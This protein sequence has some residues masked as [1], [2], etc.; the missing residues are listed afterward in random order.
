MPYYAE[1]M[2]GFEYSAATLMIFHGMVAE[3]IE[4]IQ[5]TR[6]RY[7][8]EKA[9]PYDETEYGR[10]YARAMASWAAIPALSGFRY[11]APAARIELAPRLS[12]TNFQ[13]FW[14]TPAAWGSFALTPTAV[15]LSAVAGSLSIKEL[16]IAPFAPSASLHVTSGPGAPGPSP[17][18]TGD[19]K[20][21]HQP[22]APG[23][24]GG[25]PSR[26]GTGD[27]T[28]LDR[29]FHASPTANGLLLQFSSPATVDPDH[30]LQVHA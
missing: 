18:G 13:C 1:V 11:D 7:D 6:N 9:N 23:Q 25:G 26:L 4:C 22:G 10:H 21:L 3:G 30:P 24:R 8:G 5:N 12:P 17:L 28:T 14:S 29:P 2:T 15:T 19:S 16:L 27:S 20:N